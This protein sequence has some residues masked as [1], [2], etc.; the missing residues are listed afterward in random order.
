MVRES[1]QP[2]NGRPGSTSTAPRGRGERRAAARPGRPPVARAEAALVLHY[3]RLARLAYTV[4]PATLDRHRRVLAAHALV[5]Q[6]LPSRLPDLLAGPH[7]AEVPVPRR[8]PEAAAGGGSAPA[9]PAYAQLR[10]TVLAAALQRGGRRRPWRLP[11]TWGLTLFPSS[12]GPES[13]A[14]ERALAELGTT[15]RAAYALLALEGLTQDEAG[16]L[17]VAVGVSDPRPALRRAAR[18]GA[19]YP[20]DALAAA[21]FDPCTVHA[22]PTDLLRRRRRLRAGSVLAA[23]L[24]AAAVAALVLPGSG[25]GGVPAAGAG[26]ASSLASAPAGGLGI[27][28]ADLVRVPA[29]QWRHTARIDFTAWPARGDRLTDRALLTRA[30]TL[31]SAAGERGTASAALV[32]ATPGTVPA[33]PV[34]APRLLWSGRL[35]GAEVVLLD[36]GAELARYTRPDRATAADPE[37]LQLTRSDESDVTTAGAV[38]LRSSRAGDRFLLAPWVDTVQLR[39]LR[40]PDTPAQDLVPTDGVTAAVP[41]PPSSGCGSW[42][43]LQLRSSSV[44]AEH[45]AFLLTDLGGVTAAHLT[46]TPPPS[47]GPANYPREA[48]GTDALLAWARLACGLPALRGQDVKSVNAWEFAKQPLPEGRGTALWTCTRADRW[49]GSGSAATQ[50]LAP[51]AAG[52][53]RN[54]PALT[55]AVQPK[56]RACSR[57]EQYVVAST[58]WRAPGSGHGYLLAAGSR[59]VTRLGAEGGLSAPARTVP[60]QTL[61]LPAARPNT[62]VT[63]IGTLDTG[64]TARTLK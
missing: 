52:Q 24:V 2:R 57:Y 3:T 28:A 40:A 49:D 43:V 45:H 23:A 6:S 21:D 35:D 8:S 4:L 17:L 46:F 15:E 13:L 60:Q 16:Q 38:L 10:A 37:Q 42:P 7:P 27:T 50:F 20:A 47:S 32:R 19:T 61:A 12:G 58:W 59:H 34:Q 5:Q 62:A 48:T 31:W 14:L 41:Q 1:P 33:P 26:A 30:L 36:D 29:D 39:D 9:G 64:Q 56:G 54:A 55:T 63:V 44:I 11:R 53:D 22:R 51:A 25:Q 18:L